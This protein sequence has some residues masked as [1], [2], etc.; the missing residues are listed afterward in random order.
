[1]IKYD[2]VYRKNAFDLSNSFEE[3]KNIFI[4][5]RKQERV[6]FKY[7][8]DNDRKIVKVN[9]HFIEFYCGSIYKMGGIRPFLY[10]TDCECASDFLQQGASKVNGKEVMNLEEL[11]KI[12]LEDE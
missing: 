4:K 1:M 5:N 6:K 3:I 8:I 11:V 9:D 7:F 2:V 10:N 12:V